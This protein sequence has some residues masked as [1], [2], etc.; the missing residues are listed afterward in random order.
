MNTSVELLPA[1]P[2]VSKASW[3]PV[4]KLGLPQSLLQGSAG[5]AT[6]KQQWFPFGFAHLP[7]IRNPIFWGKMSIKHITF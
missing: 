1:F 7:P 2:L 6:D 4:R 5:E 3:G